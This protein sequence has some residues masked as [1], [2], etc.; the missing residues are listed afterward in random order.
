MSISSNESILEDDIVRRQS[1]TGNV[2]DQ[3]GENQ[4]TRMLVRISQE[5]FTSVFLGDEFSF[6][7]Y[8]NVRI[9]IV[10][11]IAQ[12]TLFYG[13]YKAFTRPP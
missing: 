4:P 10:R 12:I 13:L 11:A 7:G 3:R 6:E 9:S 5:G 8:K 1:G 2:E